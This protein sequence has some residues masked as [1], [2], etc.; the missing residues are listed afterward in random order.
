MFSLDITLIMG[1]GDDLPPP[2]PRSLY[3]SMCTCPLV[4]SCMPSRYHRMLGNGMPVAEHFSETRS[5]FCLLPPL[6]SMVR[7]SKVI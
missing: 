2:P 5:A 6:V 3:V 1:V 7:S 4:Y